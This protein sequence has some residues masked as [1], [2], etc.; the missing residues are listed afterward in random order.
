[1][2]KIKTK[3]KLDI[4]TFIV[5]ACMAAAVFGVMDYR[6]D[7]YTE[8]KVTHKLDDQ[9]TVPPVIELAGGTDINETD[10]QCGIPE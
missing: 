9:D 4:A 8:W 3:R 10:N 1:M 5:L 6:N 2:R 7:S